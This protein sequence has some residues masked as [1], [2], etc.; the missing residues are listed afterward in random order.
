MKRA[1]SL[2]LGS[3][4]LVV[5]VVFVSLLTV[6]V[7]SGEVRMRPVLSG[8]MRPSLQPGDLAVTVR[9][10][11][12]SLKVGDVITFYPPGTK[13]ATLH[14]IAHISRLNSIHASDSI[15]VTTAGDANHGR[16]DPWGKIVIREPNVY[17]LYTSVPW[18]GYT[19]EL[20]MKLIKAFLLIAA[21][22]ILL[23]TISRKFATSAS[24]VLRKGN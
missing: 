11:S 8:S 13:K 10:P 19:A 6:L 24:V 21:G 4:F 23:Y 5:F 1:K 9:V 22:V 12:S 14:R 15:T 16:L 18:L 2:R 7:V 3:I 20:P 17:R